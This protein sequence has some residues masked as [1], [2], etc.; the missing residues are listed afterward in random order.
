MG[1]KK[2]AVLHVTQEAMDALKG[3]LAQYRVND[4]NYLV[5]TSGAVVLMTTGDS[6]VRI[7]VAPE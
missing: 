1:T 6:N 2:E 4:G 3:A 7:E 5:S